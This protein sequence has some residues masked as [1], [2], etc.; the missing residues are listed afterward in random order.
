MNRLN[1]RDLILNFIFLLLIQLPLIHKITLFNK[2]FGFFYVGFILLLPSRL[3]RS[4]LMLIGFF[5]GLLV[6]VFTNTPG[7]HASACVMIMFF[8][9][10]WFSIVNDGWKELT[11]LNIVTLKKTTFITYLFPLIFIHHFVLF[12]LENEG[13]SRL[14]SLFT[15]VLFSSAFS[16]LIIFII[17]FLMKSNRKRA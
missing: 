9:N 17:C 6:D 14:G 3:S 11:N 8:R 2:A 5:S 12:T 4:Y 10:F 13:L 7:I 1:I 15:K 16:F